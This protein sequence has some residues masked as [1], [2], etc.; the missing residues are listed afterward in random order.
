MTKIILYKKKLRYHPESKIRRNFSPATM[1]GWPKLNGFFCACRYF[2][3]KF[4]SA[5]CTK[6][7]LTIHW[8]NWTPAVCWT[9][10]STPN[11]R[12]QWDDIVMP[13][14]N[15]AKVQIILHI[16][17]VSIKS[18]W[19]DEIGKN[20][21]LF[22]CLHEIDMNRPSCWNYCEIVL[23]FHWAIL[24]IWISIAPFTILRET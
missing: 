24:S 11:S 14:Q 15:H 16:H 4:C 2:C 1:G 19:M 9:H 3:I 23:C 6:Y 18:V 12:S 21:S 22:S 20:I 5:N 13:S 10:S 7:W 17:W 8:F